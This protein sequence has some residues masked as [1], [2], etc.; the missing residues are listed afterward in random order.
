MAKISDDEILAL[1]ML[2]TAERRLQAADIGTG[3]TGRI[4]SESARVYGLEILRSLAR[5]GAATRLGGPHS[6]WEITE[7]GRIAAALIMSKN[8]DLCESFVESW[9]NQCAQIKETPNCLLSLPSAG[10]AEIETCRNP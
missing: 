7:K 8:P 10:Q 3:I 5:G 9:Q 2:L 1:L 4:G 6:P